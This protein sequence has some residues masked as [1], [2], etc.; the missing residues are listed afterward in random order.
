M[1]KKSQ[2]LGRGLGA[3]LGEIEDAY[4]NEVPNNSEVLE[5]AIDSIK[6]NPYQPRKN[7]DE[8]SLQ[9]LANSIKESG[10]LQP[11]VVKESV[12][13]YVLIAGERRLRASKLAKKETIKAIVTDVDDTQM[14]H[15]H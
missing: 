9:E 2:A 12:D 13:G 10:L 5:V 8:S 15:L 7:F 1:K 6:P 14:Q 3:L 4:D 11:I